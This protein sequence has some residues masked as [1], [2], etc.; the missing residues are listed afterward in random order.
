M[1]PQLNFKEARKCSHKLGGHVCALLK[2][3]FGEE[4]S[5]TKRKRGILDAKNTQ[6]SLLQF[7]STSLGNTIFVVK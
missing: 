4:G 1:W 7:A 6:Q 3:S 2:F 5:V